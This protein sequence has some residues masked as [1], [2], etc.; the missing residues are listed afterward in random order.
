MKKIWLGMCIAVLSLQI[1]ACST[2]PPDLYMT[3]ASSEG[4]SLA[5]DKP[6]IILENETDETDETAATGYQGQAGQKSGI[7]EM[8]QLMYVIDGVNIRASNSLEAPVVSSLEAG[9]QVQV[10]GKCENG[11]YRIVDQ[12]KEAYVNAE[13]LAETMPIVL[14]EAETTTQAPETTKAAETT[15][16]P[17]TTK[18]VQTT[19]AA[20]STEAI[21]ETP[22]ET[23]APTEPETTKAPIQMVNTYTMTG[24]ITNIGV[25]G[26]TVQGKDQQSYQFNCAPDVTASMKE[27]SYVVVKYN[28]EAGTEKTELVSVSG[29]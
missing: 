5:G 26:F 14:A 17:E 3:P 6:L 18:A 7:Q 15:K 25:Y 21:T 24:V 11:W 29:Q 22:P 9:V 2:E 27:G 28:S 19:A 13:F 1:T 23:A 20:D 4:G 10:T 8:N 16:A 12:S